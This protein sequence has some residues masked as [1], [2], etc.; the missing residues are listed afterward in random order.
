M[1]VKG[2]GRRNPQ[3]MGAKGPPLHCGCVVGHPFHV[4]FVTSSSETAMPNHKH[5]W[6]FPRSDACLFCIFFA[7]QRAADQWAPPA[8]NANGVL[9]EKSE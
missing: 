1:R 5:T 3:R 7:L 8:L 9:S 4:R 2:E 6:G